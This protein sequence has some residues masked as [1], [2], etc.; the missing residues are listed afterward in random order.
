MS[1]LRRYTVGE[2]Y[3]P[4]RTSWPDGVCQWRLS[5]NGVEL[6]LFYGSPTSD[7]VHAIGKGKTRFGLLAGEHSLILAH[8]FG[9]LPWSDT[10]WQACRQ[11]DTA[12]LA[13]ENGAAYAR[14]PRTVDLVQAAITTY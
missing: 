7:E 10:P 6:V 9:P 14:Y 1:N 13:H 11:T 4:S 3:N 12:G 2:L 5:P 8:K